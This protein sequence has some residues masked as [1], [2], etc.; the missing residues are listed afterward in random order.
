M[1]SDSLFNNLVPRNREGGGLDMILAE[2]KR[3]DVQVLLH[4]FT[5]SYHS[6]RRFE[7]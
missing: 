1:F 2:L 7:C 3:L 5:Q 6:W 4:S